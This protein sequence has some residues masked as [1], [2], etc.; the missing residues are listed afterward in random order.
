MSTVF[1][2]IIK[3]FIITAFGYIFYK[4]GVLKEDALSFLTF[5]VINIAFPLLIFTNII[6]NF[7]FGSGPAVSLFLGASFA[8]FALGIISG[9]LVSLTI[10]AQRRRE[11]VTL[12]TFQNCGYLP[13]NLALFLFSPARRGE[14]LVYIFLYTLGFNILMWSVGTFFIFRRKAESFQY[15]S[16]LTPPVSSVLVSL[17]VVFSGLHRHI[18]EVVIAPLKIMAE[19]S[20]PLSMIIL[21]VWLAKESSRKLFSDLGPIVKIAAVKLLFIPAIVFL[22]IKQ[23]Q[24]F[25]LLGLFL[26]V[27]AAMPSAASLPIIVD[28]RRGD[29]AFVSRGVF[30]SHM[31]SMVTVPLWLSLF[32]KVSCFRF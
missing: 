25:S 5:F 13:M 32:L 8:M 2:A 3:L 4:Q 9:G 14:F 21:G 17:I 18:P 31:I 26:L 11:S 15:R 6:A 10:P 7:S 27:E 28:M 1:L 23:I 24:L 30:F 12:A 19:T 16:L 29:S 22:F 20:F